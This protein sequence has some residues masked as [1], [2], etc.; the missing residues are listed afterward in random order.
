MPN[1]LKKILWATDFSDEAQEALVYASHFSKAFKARLLALHV[2]PDFPPNLYN[3]SA[4]IK[5]EL[6]RRLEAV[7]KEARE[8]LER[9]R[10]SKGIDFKP[11][12]SK[13][14]ASKEIIKVAEKEKADLIVIGKRGLSAI[15]KMFIGSVT[16]HVLRN[17][18]VPV[19]VTKKRPHM[20]QFK[21]VL[22][23]T[24][25]SPQEEVERDYAWNLAKGL[26][27]LEITIFHVLELHDYDFSPKA[28]E[29]MLEAALKR[30][31]K[32]RVREKEEIKISEVVYRAINAS[33]GIVDYAETNKYDLIVISTC[34]QSK[35]ERFLLGS[36]TE[37]VISLSS[38]PVF[39]IPPSR[40]AG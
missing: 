39:A 27:S 25:F 8:K 6:V 26:G 13:G 22:V 2:I 21:K 24:D 34:V 33:L 31:K 37:K 14:T 29:E 9:I 20:P 28:V 23:P 10:E 3:T 4:V 18:K 40:C 32:R 16:N 30:L 5:G 11:V 7:K 15:E 38:I 1:F 12:I 36:T 35:L 17:S 19:L